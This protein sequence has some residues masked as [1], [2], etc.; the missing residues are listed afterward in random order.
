MSNLPQVSGSNLVKAFKK[1]G[2]ILVSQKG[3]HIK[4]VK[5]FQPVGKRTLIIP[6]H[7]VIK[8]GTLTNILKDGGISIEKLKKLI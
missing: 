5:H 6:N 3:S 2:W 7:K 8:K 4:I 1:E